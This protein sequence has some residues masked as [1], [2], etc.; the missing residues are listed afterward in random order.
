MV[1]KALE[2]IYITRIADKILLLHLSV[3]V[4]NFIGKSMKGQKNGQ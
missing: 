3:F 2:I 4:Q 1:P